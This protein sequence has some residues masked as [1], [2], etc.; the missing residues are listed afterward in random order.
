MNEITLNALINLF[1]LF[2][3]INKSKKQDA[4]HNFSLYLHQ[5]FGIS[6]SKDYLQLFEELLEIYGIDGEPAFPVDMVQEATKISTNIR[7][8]L[9]KEEQV[10][11]LIRF[12]ELVKN[13]NQ[14]TAKAVFD[15]LAN[16]FEISKKDVDLFV[17][18]IYYPSTNKI[19]TPDFLL[20]NNNDHPEQ[21]SYRHIYEKNLDGEMLF[22]RCAILANYIFIFHGS[23]YLT[24][25]G[26]PV[27]TGRFYAFR[28]GS[29][30]RGPRISPIYYTDIA[31]GFIDRD[32][33]PSFVFSGEEIEYKFKNSNNGLHRFSFSEK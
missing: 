27:I 13:G 15:T 4:L 11:V 29:I 7:G 21:N 17:A 2:S 19:N 23:E 6:D 5:H 30:I 14:S 1:A 8:L 26:N 18:F 9:N 24:I 28:E 31:T 32:L 25:D 22:L 12:L 33:S 10:M 3:V 16:V 20:V